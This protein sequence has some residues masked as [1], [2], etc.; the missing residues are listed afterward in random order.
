MTS[1]PSLPLCICSTGSVITVP[2]IIRCASFL[3]NLISTPTAITTA[4]AVTAS[5]SVML[6]MAQALLSGFTQFTLLISSNTPRGKFQGAT[7]AQ[8]GTEREGGP[9]RQNNG[10]GTVVTLSCPV[11]DLTLPSA[12]RCAFRR[13]RG[14]NTAGCRCSG[15]QN[16]C[17]WLATLGAHL[18]KAP[19][20][21]LLK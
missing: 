18:E 2:R 21:S 14:P 17:P 19:L 7:E 10:D 16:L 5:I 4:I 1:Q 6:P 20:A 13:Q 11:L 12:S 9:S 8:K 15:K 3:H